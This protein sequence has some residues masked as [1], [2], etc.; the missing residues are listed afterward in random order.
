M[1]FSE[2]AT[3]Y[4][5]ET[6]SLWRKKRGAAHRARA[7]LGVAITPVCEGLSHRL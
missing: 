2:R 3:G 1:T 4:M 6:S 5:R 7:R